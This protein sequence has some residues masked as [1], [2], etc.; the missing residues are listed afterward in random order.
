MYYSVIPCVSICT[1]NVKQSVVEWSFADPSRSVILDVIFE[2]AS[3]KTVPERQFRSVWQH[4]GAPE[5]PF[6][7]LWHGVAGQPFRALGRHRG[8]PEEPCRVL[9]QH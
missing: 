8:S 2:R 9:W 1:N 6:G 4:Q 5:Q 7:T 3:H